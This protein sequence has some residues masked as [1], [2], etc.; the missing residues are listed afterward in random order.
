MSLNIYKLH[1]NERNVY[2]NF[3]LELGIIFKLLGLSVQLP[4]R[5]KHFF[6]LREVARIIFKFIYR[7]H[8]CIVYSYYDID[9]FLLFQIRFLA[10]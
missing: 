3:L 5:T 9:L 2:N 4:V 8:S 7:L 1:K 10:I 6:T